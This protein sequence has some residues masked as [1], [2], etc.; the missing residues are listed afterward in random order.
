MLA[1]YTYRRGVFNRPFCPSSRHSGEWAFSRRASEVGT[2]FCVTADSQTSEDQTVTIRNR[3]SMEQV[4]VPMD[5]LV[6]WLGERV[7]T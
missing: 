3:D 7:G 5:R 1:H 2:P 4:R 6:E